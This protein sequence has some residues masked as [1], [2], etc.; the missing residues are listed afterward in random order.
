MA[1][2]GAA[3]PPSPSAPSKADDDRTVWQVPVGKSPVR[4]KATALVTLV[5]WADFQ[6][7]FCGRVTPT[8]KKL[9]T[10]YGD[11]LRVVFKHNPL[12]FHPHA[13]PA[14][15]LALEARAQRGDRGF[16]AAHDLLFGK[17]CAGAK[18][19]D[20]Q[21]CMDAGGTWMDHQTQLDDT[22]LLGYAKAL[23]L[24]VGKVQAAIA[25]KKHAATIMEDQDLGDDLQASGTPHFFINGRRLVGAQSIEKFRA[26]I[27]E[28]LEK[29]QKMV[30][31][32]VAAGLVYEKIAATGK[33]AP[34]PER[35]TVPAPTRANPARGP[36]SATV[37]VQMF[38]DFQC[39]FCKRSLQTVEDLEK[40]FPGKIRVVWMN[41]PLP[42]HNHAALAAEAAM[43]AFRQKGDTGFWAMHALLFAGQGSSGL[44][45][46]A[47][48]GYAAQL[49][50]DAAQFAAALDARAHKAEVDADAKIAADAGISGTPAF[51]I[52]GYFLNGAQPLNKFRRIVERALAEP[53]KKG[54]T[55]PAVANQRAQTF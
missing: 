35:K 41:L 25:G 14:A 42:M 2:K 53:G 44:E 47:L 32:G 8:V 37:T 18:G 28:E 1:Q 24:D 50:L 38:A 33:G 15:E 30:K 34:P 55:L 13:E 54:T 23:G 51:V 17:E 43:E 12:P 46:P 29:A 27:D 49:G 16:W 9:Q 6:C 39:P 11:K 7:P 5:E 20:R 52:N 19:D 10:E 22:D 21:S 3:P 36:A 4:G 45:R 26:V 48:D 40:A 31:K